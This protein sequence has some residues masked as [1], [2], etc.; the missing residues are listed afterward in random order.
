MDAVSLGAKSAGGLTIGVLPTDKSDIASEGVDFA[1]LTG[2]GDARNS[3]NVLSSDAVVVCGMNP[4]TACEVALAIKAVKPIILVQCDEATK[5]FFQQL[6]KNTVH[7]C[8][9]VVQ[10]TD[11]LK[12]LLK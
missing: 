6:S 5:V 3:I 11:L 2:M 12:S 1:I 10:T 4:G 8:E 7:T 9:E